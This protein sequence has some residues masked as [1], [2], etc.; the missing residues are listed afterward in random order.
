MKRVSTSL[1]LAGLALS[2]AQYV[3]AAT[4]AD[5]PLHLVVNYSN[6]DVSTP[7]GAKFLYDR[8]HEAAEQVCAPL[9]RAGDMNLTRRYRACVQTAV[10][11]AVQELDKPLLTQL[12]LERTG[13]FKPVTMASVK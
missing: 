1:L 4:S 3:R 6:V 9:D 11:N 12:F 5:T 2:A 10:S 13:G 7:A 8:L